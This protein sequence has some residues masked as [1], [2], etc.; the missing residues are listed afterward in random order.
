MKCFRRTL[1]VDPISGQCSD[2]TNMWDW[3]VGRLKEVLDYCWD[4]SIAD[5]AKRILKHQKE[6]LDKLINETP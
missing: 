6:Q 5:L 2:G 3:G 4:A 1:Y